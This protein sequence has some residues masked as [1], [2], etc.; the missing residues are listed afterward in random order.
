M[1]RT[2]QTIL[3]N[4]CMITDGKGNV[5][6]Q[7]KHSP[8]WSGMTYPGGHVEPG[9]SFHDA[10]LREVWEETGLTIRNPSLCGIKQFPMEDGSRYIVLL[11][12][13]DQFSGELRSSQEG[14]VFWMPMTE[15]DRYEWVPDFDLMRLVFE[16]NYSEFCY[17]REDGALKSLLYEGE[18]LW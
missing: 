17:V 4:M 3:T 5:V 8:G 9:E 18:K 10:V 14:K 7:E 2:E 16:E 11:Y 6:V 15:F 1:G 13:A 12:R